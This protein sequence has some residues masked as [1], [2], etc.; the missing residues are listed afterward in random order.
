MFSNYNPFILARQ[1]FLGVGAAR[2]KA[3]R[4]ARKAAQ[5]GYGKGPKKAKKLS[6]AGSGVPLEEVIRFKY[7]K[8]F[9]QAVRIPCNKND[10][11]IF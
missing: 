8:G 10:F 5:V 1:N 11:T 7:Q 4:S 6:N 3:A 9:T 2:A